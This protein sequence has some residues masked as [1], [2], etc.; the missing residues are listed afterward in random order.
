VCGL[1][2]NRIKR[3]TVYAL[4]RTYCMYM[5][6]GERQTI[7][8]HSTEPDLSHFTVVSS[9]S[10]VSFSDSAL[11]SYCRTLHSYLTVGLCT[12]VLL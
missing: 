8:H 1:N 2:E 10:F 7:R 12:A 4:F 11:L 6:M 3:I 5:T 9:G